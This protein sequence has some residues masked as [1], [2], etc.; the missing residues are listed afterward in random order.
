[1]NK[2]QKE[3]EKIRF[4]EEMNKRE[5]VV[6][7]GK[8]KIPLDDYMEQER[9]AKKIQPVDTSKLFGNNKMNDNTCNQDTGILAPDVVFETYIWYIRDARQRNLDLRNSRRRR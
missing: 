9:Y 8:S 5:V 4:I 6:T 1:M 3:Q 2:K 7:D